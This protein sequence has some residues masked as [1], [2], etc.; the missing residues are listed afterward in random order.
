MNVSMMDAYDLAWKL[1]YAIHG[2]TPDPQALLETFSYDRRE[3]ALNLIDLDKRWYNMRLASLE[4]VVKNFADYA[5]AEMRSFISGVGIEY[6]AGFLVDEKSGSLPDGPINSTDFV[7]GVLREGRRFADVVVTRFVDGVPRHTQDE[8]PS[9]GRF[10][11]LVLASMDLLDPSGVSAKTLTTVCEKILPSFTS[12]VLEV[13]VLHPLELHSFEWTDVPASVKSVAEM[14]FH[15]A[16]ATA[17]AAYG[18]DQAR[19][20]TAVIRPDGY[21]GT[22][23]HLDDLGKVEGY[24]KRCL[25]SRTKGAEK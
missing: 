8:F 21:V 16:D 14:Q 23:G 20:G 3:N 18:V 15:C 12:G 22:I 24:L 17:Y 2:L 10:R 5:Q 11:V 6:D 1:V 7:S 19:G 25:Q 9:N 4:T 13:V